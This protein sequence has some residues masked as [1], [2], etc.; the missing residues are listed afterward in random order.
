MWDATRPN[1]HTWDFNI[2]ELLIF[3]Y[4]QSTV[5]PLS[6][7]EVARQP[8]T[9]QP[10]SGAGFPSHP[11]EPGP[12]QGFFLLKRSFFLPLFQVEKKALLINI[13]NLL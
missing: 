1:G 7:S 8:V 11:Y 3:K 4:L 6:G 13:Y 9:M 10:R 5:S 12:A 2:N